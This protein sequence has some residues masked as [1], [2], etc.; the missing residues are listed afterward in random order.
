MKAKV[1]GKT[2]LIFEFI[3]IIIVVFLSV[4]FWLILGFQKVLA[5]EELEQISS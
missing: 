1:F 4:V 5:N 3:I 2:A